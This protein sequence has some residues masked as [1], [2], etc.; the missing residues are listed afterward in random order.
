MPRRPRLPCANLD[1]DYILLS[2]ALLRVR[3]EGDGSTIQQWQNKD[4]TLFFWTRETKERH[5]ETVIGGMEE[6]C[7]QGICSNHAQRLN[8]FWHTSTGAGTNPTRAKLPTVVHTDGVD[9]SHS[10]THCLSKQSWFSLSHASCYWTLMEAR[11]LWADGTKTNGAR[12]PPQYR[13]R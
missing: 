10:H 6:W 9:W 1:V 13:P 4:G 5:N 3:G 11:C 7:W 12:K 8:A 2:K